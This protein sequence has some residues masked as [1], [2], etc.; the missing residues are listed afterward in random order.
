MNALAHRGPTA[1]KVDVDGLEWPILR[2]G[3]RTLALAGMRSV[4]IELS[5]TH[6]AERSQAIEWLRERGLVL[7]STGAPQGSGGEQAANHLFMRRS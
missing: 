5:L 3:E 7:A 4:M 2:G 6:D 1:I